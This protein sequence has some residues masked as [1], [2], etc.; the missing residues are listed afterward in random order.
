MLV[1]H[2]GK[3]LGNKPQHWAIN[4]AWSSTRMAKARHRAWVADWQCL[5][6]SSG[7]RQTAP[8]PCLGHNDDPMMMSLR[9]EGTFALHFVVAAIACMRARWK[10]ETSDLWTIQTTGLGNLFHILRYYFDKKH[11]SCS[12]LRRDCLISGT[13]MNID[14]S[15]RI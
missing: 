10:S 6:L 9:S 11:E 2:S 13:H 14:M 8:K 3:L 12:L 1:C 7:E 15:L 4:K 5:G